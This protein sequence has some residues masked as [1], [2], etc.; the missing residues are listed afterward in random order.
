M[1]LSV[2]I[3][4]YNR[5]EALARSLET[6]AVQADTPGFSWEVIVV[7][8]R[9]MDKTPTIAKDYADK[10]KNIRYVREDQQGLSYARNRGIAEAQGELL[11]F[12]DDD[13]LLPP[14]YIVR[15]WDCRQN[16][17]W[18]VAGGRAIGNYEVPCPEWARRLPPQMLNGPFGLHDRGPDDFVLDENDDTSPIGANMLIPKST[19]EKLGGFDTNLG[20][21][22]KSLR[23]GEDSE[24]YDRA[25]QAGM[26]IGCCGSCWLKHLVQKERLSRR[27]MLRWK[28]FASLTGSNAPLPADTVFWLGVPR[29]SWRALFESL[30]RLPFALC[31]RRRM[32]ALILLSGKLGAVVG[33][34]TGRR[35]WSLAAKK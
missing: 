12:V 3:C 26:K 34:L 24:F 20:R 1:N 8:N 2:I 14:D 23:S 31:T 11:C 4:T 28:F 21:S 18:D 16:G 27:F 22:G 10:H 29:Y 5:F 30:I 15:A 25:R 9:S 32:Q 33:Y 6:A 7:D 19:L 35:R 13:V 17:G